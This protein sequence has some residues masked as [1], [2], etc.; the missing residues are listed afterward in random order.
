[1]QSHDLNPNATEMEVTGILVHNSASIPIKINDLDVPVALRKGT[2][3][4][5]LH[6]ISKFVSYYSLS[7]FYQTLTSNLSSVEIANLYTKL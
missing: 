6:P 7:S 5:T 2:W 4:S 1:M 3:S